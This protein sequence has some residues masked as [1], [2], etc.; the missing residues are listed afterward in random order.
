MII[1]FTKKY[2]YGKGQQEVDRQDKIF[3]EH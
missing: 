3:E 2:Q 1:I